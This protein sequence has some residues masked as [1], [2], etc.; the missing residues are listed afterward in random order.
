VEGEL[1]L[2][3]MLWSFRAVLSLAG[4]LCAWC[5]SWFHLKQIPGPLG[6]YTE[7]ER[8]VVRRVDTNVDGS[9]TS[10]DSHARFL[11][12][13]QQYGDQPM[14]NTKT[15]Q[16]AEWAKEVGVKL[17]DSGAVYD[18]HGT[19]VV[20][21]SRGLQPAEQSM[22][23]AYWNLGDRPRRYA[24]MVE[25]MI[26][27]YRQYV[28]YLVPKVLPLIKAF[29]KLDL[30]IFWSNWLRRPDDGFYGALDRF[31]GPMGV[32]SKQN[33]AYVYA[34]NGSLPMTELMPTP[35]EVAK[36]RMFHSAHLSK[37][38]DL[39]E[40]GQSSW[41]LKLK[42]LG[43]DTLIVTGAWTED[44]IAAT[45]YDA[46][47]KYNIDTVIVTDGVGTA[48]PSHFTG[49]D[50]EGASAAKLMSSADIVEFLKAHGAEDAYV[51]KSAS[52]SLSAVEQAGSDTVVVP[53]WAVAAV[54]LFSFFLG[55]F[56]ASVGCKVRRNRHMMMADSL[57]EPLSA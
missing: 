7:A 3:A 29:R 47:D 24:L 16:A 11:P 33:P 54:A 44:C 5:Q 4:L 53:V 39:N 26:E 56:W 46:V 28:G 1:S 38:A 42:A 48:T 19:K 20:N 14:P 6:D 21:T 41:F 27:D 37:F 18:V 12:A 10:L 35:E 22:Y 23:W 17:L 34:Q 45:A 55:M 57:V 49:L 31:Y 15:L 52:S 43:V 32:K 50:V 2:Q 25:D 51:L 8:E 36:G 9:K 40:E 30:P 13:I